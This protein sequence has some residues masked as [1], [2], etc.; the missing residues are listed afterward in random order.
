[1]RISAKTIT[2][3][4]QLKNRKNAVTKQYK[5]SNKTVTKQ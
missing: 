5:N 3:D 2:E 1:M 4:N